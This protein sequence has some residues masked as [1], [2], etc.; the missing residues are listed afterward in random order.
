MTPISIRVKTESCH[1]A[2]LAPSH[3]Q[4]APMPLQRSDAGKQGQTRA[5][6]WHSCCNCTRNSIILSILLEGALCSISTPARSVL[7]FCGMVGRGIGR[8]LPGMTSAALGHSTSSTKISRQHAGFYAA[9]Q[10]E[11]SRTSSRREDTR[12]SQSGELGELGR[13]TTLDC[14]GTG[15]E[16]A[17]G[18]K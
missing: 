6:G 3:L 4:I 17:A 11:S 9:R 12:R 16:Q 15:Y 14:C 13:Q 2:Q 5:P 10:A 7:H 1:K 18:L 8:H